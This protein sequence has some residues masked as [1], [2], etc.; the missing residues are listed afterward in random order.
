MGFVSLWLISTLPVLA[1]AQQVYVSVSGPVSRKH[2][3]NVQQTKD[4]AT[5]TSIFAPNK[6]FSYTL[7]E[8]TNSHGHRV[9]GTRH[10]RRALCQL[11]D[12]RT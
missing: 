2:C 5:A 8:S 11:E 7:T 3:Q 9:H 4:Y 10:L 1:L 12:P 6:E